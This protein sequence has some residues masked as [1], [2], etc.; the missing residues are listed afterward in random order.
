MSTDLDLKLP[1]WLPAV[2]RFAATKISQREEDA[3][4]PDDLNLL[5]R[6]ASD[7][8]MHNV[9]RTLNK[10][11]TRCERDRFGN[12]MFFYS[13]CWAPFKQE[14]AS[15]LRL[16]GGAHNQA[17][18]R[19]IE[20]EAHRL[21]RP[22]SEDS[23]SRPGKDCALYC[24]FYGAYH[25]ARDLSPLPSRQSIKVLYDQYSDVEEQLRQIS[26][27]LCALGMGCH[28]EELLPMIRDVIDAKTFIVSD[29]EYRGFKIADRERSDWKLRSLVV[30]LAAITTV[31][32]GKPLYGTLAATENIPLD[33]KNTVDGPHIREI[34]RSY[35]YSAVDG[36][37][38]I[39]WD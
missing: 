26:D 7:K 15:K 29:C 36:V 25:I 33:L 28:A 1:E 39:P 19:Y 21:F 14:E 4:A 8:R 22:S 23:Q 38:P 3:E 27:K 2:V 18:A 12:P 5:I 34:L 11:K 37:C 30:Q 35:P 17:T 10:T 32:F 20:S 24:Y 16:E 6:L 31:V 9:W 13:N